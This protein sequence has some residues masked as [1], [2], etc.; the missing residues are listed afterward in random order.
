MLRDVVPGALQATP[1][2]CNTSAKPRIVGPDTL[3]DSAG[4]SH[5]RTEQAQDQLVPAKKRRLTARF[6]SRS[7][8]DGPVVATSG[9]GV[10]F[11]DVCREHGDG[12]SSV[13][14]RAYSGPRSGS[15]RPPNLGER[16]SIELDAAIDAAADAR[17]SCVRLLK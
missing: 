11:R 12:I 17:G 3:N 15:L 10:M 5:A 14:R 6:H 8:L 2:S 4:G 7:E 9:F 13:K 1:S 16:M